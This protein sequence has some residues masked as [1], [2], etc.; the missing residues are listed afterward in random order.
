MTKKKINQKIISQIEFYQMNNLNIIIGNSPKNRFKYSSNFENRDK[1]GKL[2]LL[3]KKIEEIKNCNLKKNAKKIVFSDGNINSK[4]MLIGEG[5]GA[6]EDET[7][8]PFVGAA[9]K[10][11]DKMLEAIKLDRNNVY[12]TNVVN[13]RPPNNRKPTDLEIK[14]YVP[15][16]KIHIEIINPKILVLLGSTALQA[17]FD[18]KK[19]ISKERGKWFK[20]KIGNCE[21]E[22]IVSFH[23]AFLIRQPEQKKFAWNDLKLLRKKINFLNL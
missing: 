17:I 23:P 3:K 12:I 14:K 7:G 15:F 8:L 13:Y 1:K 10:L 2:Y 19:I 20:N 11:L 4:I 5:P 16:L 21:P 18:E 6:Q 9:G 22:I